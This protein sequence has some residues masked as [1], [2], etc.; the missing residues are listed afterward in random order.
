MHKLILLLMMTFISN[1]VL[2]AQ[3]ETYYPNYDYD[4]LSTNNISLFASNVGNLYPYYIFGALWDYGTS[5]TDIVYDQGLCVIGKI[6]GEIKSSPVQWVSLYS[7]G[8]IINN[9]AA[10][11][12]A[13]E[14]SLRY[15]VYKISIGDENTNPDYDEW[16]ADLGAPVDDQNNP[17][18]YGDQ[19]LW[20][21]YNGVRRS[22]VVDY[23]QRL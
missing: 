10:M 20:T 22:N 6:N 3:V 23:L 7:P 11:N 19:M 15:R 16:P 5:Q 2:R 18:L 21:I 8:P 13:A 17:L 4:G 12:S 14:D 1:I 9:D